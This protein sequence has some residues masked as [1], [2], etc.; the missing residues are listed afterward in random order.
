MRT[1]AEA[2]RSGVACE[3]RTVLVRGVHDVESVSWI[4][5][6]LAETGV[7]LWRLRDVQDGRVLDRSEPLVPPD[8]AVGDHA[9]TLAAGLGLDVRWF[10]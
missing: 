4:A 7:K 8:K 1:L 2:S 10:R 3:A 6:G 9:Q 5:E